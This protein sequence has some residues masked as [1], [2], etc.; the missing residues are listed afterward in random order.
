LRQ[1]FGLPYGPSERRSAER[2]LAMFRFIYPW[3]PACLRYVAPYHEALARLAGRERP[4]ALTRALNRLWIGQT[5][6]AAGGK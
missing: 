6:M 1:E 4:G 2:A 5:S 3:M